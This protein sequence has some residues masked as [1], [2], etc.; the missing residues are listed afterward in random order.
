MGVMLATTPLIAFAFAIIFVM[1]SRI[2]SELK[3]KQRQLE[4]KLLSIVRMVRNLT[5]LM[6]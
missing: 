2:S 5:N 1:I 4:S 3:L 6:L